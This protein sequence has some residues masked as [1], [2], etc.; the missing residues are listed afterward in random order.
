MTR[1]TLLISAVIFIAF[2]VSVLFLTSIVGLLDK[3]AALDKHVVQ[4]LSAN[5]ITDRDIIR[6]SREELRRGMRRYIHTY[7]DYKVKGV[8]FK[9]V[10]KALERELAKTGFSVVRSDYSSTKGLEEI[11]YVI[12]FK[13]FDIMS[14]KLSQKRAEKVPGIKKVYPNPKVAIVLDDF[15][16]TMENVKPLFDIGL[17]VTFSIL[18]N[19]KYSSIISKEAH[20]RGYEVILHLPLEPHRKDVTE[21]VNTINSR[22][23][24]R[25]VLA[26]LE[27]DMESVPDLVGVSNHMGSQSTEERELMAIIFRTLKD[28][29]LFFLD[30][31]VTNKSVCEEVAQKLGLRFAK[32]SVFLDN[33]LEEEHVKNQIY[34]LK[35]KAFAT[36]SAVA[37]GHDRRVTVK[38][39]SEEMPALEKEGIRFVKVSE[40]AK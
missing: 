1:K 2:I 22:L 37:I 21:E 12:R 30:S 3:S 25:E 34:R 20:E 23:P 33:T 13:G 24:K 36:G 8:N 29:G 18:P 14:I 38:V 27:S 4:V 7:R 11:F 6:E 9:N 28:K 39:L 40:L 19:L 5:D 35:V 17:P 31:Y 32:R 10:T 26:R 15:G 16:Y